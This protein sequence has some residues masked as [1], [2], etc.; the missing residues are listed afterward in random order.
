MTPWRVIVAGGRN[1]TD[2]ALLYNTLNSLSVSL[3]AQGRAIRIVSGGARGT[4]ALGEKWAVAAGIPPIVVSAEWGNLDAP[5]AV[6]KRTR[7]GKLY[8]AKAGNDRNEQMA[9]Q[10][11]ELVAFWDGASKGTGHMI[12]IATSV[13]LPV[14]VV[15]FD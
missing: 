7:T 1:F 6:I 13:G 12:D 5:G 14:T 10:A 15:R 2:T 11:E 9:K 4:D 8:N 3:A